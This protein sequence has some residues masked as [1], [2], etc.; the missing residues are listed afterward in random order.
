MNQLRHCAALKAIQLLRDL[1]L[2]P[3]SADAYE[4]FADDA[5]NLL[6]TA[7]GLSDDLV[8]VHIP[9]AAIELEATE[10]LRHMP[11]AIDAGTLAQLPL[12]YMGQAPDMR[13]DF[14]RY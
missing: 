11:G 12:R 8:T 9:R 7:D 5:G 2:A 14:V 10:L 3:G 4:L 6:L 13:V 1:Q